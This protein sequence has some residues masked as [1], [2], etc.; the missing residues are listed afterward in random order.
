MVAEIV[1]SISEFRTGTE[2]RKREIALLA[3]ELYAADRFLR[4]V[5]HGIPA[6]LLDRVQSIATP[7]F[8]QD[9]EAKL[10]LLARSGLGYLPSP[11]SLNLAVSR[12]P[13]T[14]HEQLIV[15]LDEE[16][17]SWPAVPSDFRQVVSRYCREAEKLSRTMSEMLALGVGIPAEQVVEREDAPNCSFLKFINWQSPA[18][19]IRISDY[20]LAPHYDNAAVSVLHNTHQANGLQVL[21]ERGWVD[22]FARPGEL[23]VL[24]GE[25]MTRWT[26]GRVT[27]S[28]HQ[29]INHADAYAGDGSRLS[30]CYFYNP[31]PMVEDVER[32][33]AGRA[34][35][36]EACDASLRG[37][38]VVKQT[39]TRRFR[40]NSN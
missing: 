8:Q 4:I 19:G 10:Q 28:W 36:C 34:K 30:S 18:A 21:A 17:N 23:L 40:L 22:L 3:A 24:F 25:Q 27:P 33:L 6:Q 11:D 16:R 2:P 9:L 35:Y 37:E 12:N 20:R 26:N 29:V 31:E 15:H 32:Y 7:F 13:N 1:V 39:W 38:V 14:M 5:D